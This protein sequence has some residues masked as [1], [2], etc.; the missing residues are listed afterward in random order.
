[1]KSLMSPHSPPQSK[2]FSKRRGQTVK[3]SS[4][5]S[6]AGHSAAVNIEKHVFYPMPMTLE[7]LNGHPDSFL[8]GTPPGSKSETRTL[9]SHPPKTFICGSLPSSDGSDTSRVLPTTC[10]HTSTSHSNRQ[11]SRSRCRE[12]HARLE[13]HQSDR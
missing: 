7:S 5:R 3:H 10:Q 4:E 13:N 2:K 8:S 1:M 12:K 6:S 11:N 9:P